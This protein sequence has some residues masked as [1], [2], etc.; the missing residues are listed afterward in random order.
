MSK[1]IENLKWR[2]ATK[3]FDSTKKIPQKE[4]ET[5]LEALQLSASSYGMQFYK[6]LIIKNSQVRE[7]LKEAS[8][9]QA[10]VSEA[11]DLIVMCSIKSIGDAHVDTAVAN[12]GEIRS[13]PSQDLN[14][15]SNFVK[16]KVNELNK[17]EK[18]HWTAKQV[19]IALG[20]ALSACAELRIDACPMEGFDP[21]KYDE[22]LGL[23]AKGL[24]AT[25]VL[26]IGYRS[27]DDKSQHLKKAR[28]SKEN[29][30]EMIY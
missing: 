11:S 9:G 1:I 4:L 16:S 25:L 24:E 18:M 8:W 14:G 3:K 20:F 5:L 23:S 17:E 21:Q 6:F 7:K 12:T 10:Q 19:Y 26:P 30:F 28:K 13:I 22:I 2:Y 15:Y 29:L 27:Q